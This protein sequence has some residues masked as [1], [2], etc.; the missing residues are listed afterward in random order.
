MATK[1]FRDRTTR[2]LVRMYTKAV[3]KVLKH[4]DKRES[5][6]RDERDTYKHWLDIL[7]GARAELET[8]EV[9]L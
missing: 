6:Y 9:T 4:R 5:N 8:R 3:K 7:R 1:Y 2:N